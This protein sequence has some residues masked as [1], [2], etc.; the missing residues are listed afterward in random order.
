MKK[1][2]WIGHKI[3]AE[4][5]KKLLDNFDN[6]TVP[7]LLDY[8]PKDK[9]A[10]IMDLGCGCGLMLGYLSRLGYRNL[11]GIDILPE[12]IEDARGRLDPSTELVCQDI[13]DYHTEEK[14]DLVLMFD[15]LEHFETSDGSEILKI[16]RNLLKPEGAV[17][18]RVPHAATVLAS[19]IRYLGPDHRVIFMQGGLDFMMFP[20]GFD[21]GEIINTNKYKP[22]WVRVLIK[23]KDFCYYLLY[24]LHEMTV[25]P[26]FDS[27]L[28]MVFKL[29][30]KVENDH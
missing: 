14:Y 2:D 3:Y 5:N 22:L 16:V 27:K 21:R 24:R 7:Y 9:N 15:I 13:R 23:F 12:M 6:Y 25:P 17:I 30:Q 19:S 10:K 4:S 20:I 29:R 18:I 11:T 1:G 8:L 26:T 28:T